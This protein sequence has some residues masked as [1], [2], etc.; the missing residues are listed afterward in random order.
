MGLFGHSGPHLVL[1]SLVAVTFTTGLLGNA[2]LLFLI[3]SDSRLHTPMYF[4]LSQLS[5]LDVG[6]PLVTMPKMAA[7]FLQGESSISFE[8]CAAQMF[9][10]MLL[11][12]SEGVLLSLMSYDRYVAVC[13]PLRYPVLMRRQ[14]C[15]LMVGTS[16]SLG[17]LVSSIQTSI[18]LHFPYCAINLTCV[19]KI[20]WFLNAAFWEDLQRLHHNKVWRITFLIISLFSWSIW[21]LRIPDIS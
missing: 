7:N 3:H 17:V 21:T 19:W 10:L 13:D 1:F 16:W 9:F 2:V 11:G 12:V 8:G 20:F 15:L 18:T 6:F 4:L 14:V 5:L